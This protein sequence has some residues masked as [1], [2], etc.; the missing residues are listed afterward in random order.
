MKELTLGIA[1]F[2]NYVGK[3]VDGFEGV[4]GRNEIGEQ[5]LEDRMLLEFGD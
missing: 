1:D 5:N 3:I 4:N 2:N